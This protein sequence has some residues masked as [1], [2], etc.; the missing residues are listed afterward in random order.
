MTSFVLVNACSDRAFTQTILE[1]IATA[2]EVQLNRDVA[3][4]YGGNFRVRAASPANPPAPGEDPAAIVNDL[5]DAPGAVAYHDWVGQVRI[6]A[7]RN[8]CATLTDGPASLSSA[9]SHELIET[10]GDEGCNMWVDDN[11]GHEYAHELCD[12]VESTSYTVAVGGLLVAVSDFLLPSF[13]LSGSSAPY[14]FMQ[15]ATG[16]MVGG[17][18]APFLTAPGGYQV[19]R[20]SGVGETQITGRIPNEKL[21]KKRNPCSRTYRRG[22]R[23]TAAPQAG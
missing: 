1:A 22:W 4:V 9:L 21:A 8:M 10:V 16:S 11:V 14:S 19:M 23:H 7:A 3:P 6:Y 5:P 12:A 15:S 18:V 17:P 13:F 2:L 20:S